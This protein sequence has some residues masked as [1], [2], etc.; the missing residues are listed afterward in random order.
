MSLKFSL[1][2]VISISAL[3]TGVGFAQTS[4][5]AL[6][7]AP[8]SSLYVTD[9]SGSHEAK[10]SSGQASGGAG[11]WVRRGVHDQVDIY[12]SPFKV[13]NLKWTLGLSAVTAVLIATDKHASGQLSRN[14]SNVSSDI[15]NAGLVVTVGSASALLVDG[16]ARDNPH[17]RETGVLAGE[18]I[19]DSGILYAVAQLI[20]ERN[21]PLQDSGKGHFFQTS[22]LDNSFPSGHAV[23]TWAAATTIAHE[24]PKPWVEWLAYGTATAVSVTRFTSAQHFPS[25]AVVGSAF[26]YLVARHVFHAHCKSGLGSAC[27]K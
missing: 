1:A 4:L 11:Y 18:S 23:F 19:V 26:G 8:S 12:S 25:D 17:A 14:P 7:D 20:T 2:H 5:S 6:P 24:Y 16:L 27:H 13:A 15:S 9:D 10:P 3:L 21:R 22:G